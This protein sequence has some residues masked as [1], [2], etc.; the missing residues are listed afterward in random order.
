[1][2]TAAVTC[3]VEARLRRVAWRH[4]FVGVGVGSAGVRAAQVAEAR[5]Q[6]ALRWMHGGGGSGW[7]RAGERRRERG[8]VEARWRDRAA[9]RD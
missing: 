1:M 2:C 9:A 6:A 8:R 7:R 3:G 4:G 5:A